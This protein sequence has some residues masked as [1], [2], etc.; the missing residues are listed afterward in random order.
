MEIIV[1]TYDEVVFGFRLI[2]VGEVN[3]FKI[4]A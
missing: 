4:N 3:P 2:K 1:G